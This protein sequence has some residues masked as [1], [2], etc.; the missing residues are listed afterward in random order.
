MLQRQTWRQ[1]NHSLH[2]CPVL[3]SVR[4][5]TIQ[6]NFAY[7]LERPISYARNT[8]RTNEFQ[9][10]S[11]RLS[12]V[13]GS[14]GITSIKEHTAEPRRTTRLRPP[15]PWIRPESLS[16]SLEAHR[17]A[18]HE[19]IARDGVLQDAPKRRQ[20]KNMKH[21]LQQGPW[22]DT[23]VLHL[24]PSDSSQKFRADYG[25]ICPPLLSE[26]RPA[27]HLPL[28]LRFP[29]TYRMDLHAGQVR[30]GTALERLSAEMVACD[31]YFSA[32]PTES[33]AATRAFAQIKEILVECMGS[34]TSVDLIGSRAAGTQGPV[35]DLD[36][37]I[38]SGN[39]S[40]GDDVS[41][42]LLTGEQFFKMFTQLRKKRYADVVL[43]HVYLNK[44]YVPIVV[45]THLPSGLEFQIQSTLN[46]QDSLEVTRAFIA[47]YPK[48]CVLFKIVKQILLIRGLSR[49]SSGGV[50]SY[51]LFNMVVT[52]LKLGSLHAR[53][54]DIAT[55]LLEFLNFWSEFNFE[56]YKIVLTSSDAIG[57]NSNDT[58]DTIDPISAVPRIVPKVVAPTTKGFMMSLEDPADVSND[59]G[60]N[61]SG[62]KHVQACFIEAREQIRKRMAAWDNAC[63]YGSPILA[64]CLGGDYT[65]F[66]EARWQVER[67]GTRN[68]E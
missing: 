33:A 19:G 54:D 66:E 50:T 40:G 57:K 51:P 27:A 61:I 67:Y 53:P 56:G 11:R 37:N 48:A 42:S 5:S 26:W 68:G 10:H 14:E 36:I 18:N 39:K 62:I 41:H 55:Q 44:T 46:V 45:G 31:R 16:E 15:E 3:W 20:R 4:Q 32:S 59:L 35:S 49:G 65:A 23:K 13:P 9:N 63:D 2:A 22:T 6:N 29:W 58:P 52:S 43:P 47:E 1:L 28:R 60:R 30:H 17:K 7:R 8:Y 24:P 12:S 34:S 25:G 38:H 21:Q 64:W